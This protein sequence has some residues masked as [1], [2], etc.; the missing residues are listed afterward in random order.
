VVLSTRQG[1]FFLP[2]NAGELRYKGVE[3]GARVAFSPQVAV[4]AN[5][6]FYHNRFGAFV[7]QSEDG[8]EVLTGNRLP[9][10]PAHVVNWGATVKP[11]RAVEAT[12]NV[13]HISDVQSNREN[14]FLL[15]PYSTV[16]AAVSWRRGPIR[17]T[18]SA[19]NLLNTE[20]YWNSDGETA[21]PGRPRQVLFTFS[22]LAK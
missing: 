8:D 15:D 20:Y 3:T 1:P 21:D 12:L 10:S 9:I 4:Y 7:I 17:M 16:D 13:K 22:V 5:A 6:S 14:S 18:L 11:A 19:H 2:T